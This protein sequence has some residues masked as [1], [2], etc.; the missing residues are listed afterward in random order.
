MAKQQNSVQHYLQIPIE[1]NDV[2]ASAKALRISLLK[3]Q[4]MAFDNIDADFLRKGD[5]KSLQTVTGLMIQ[6]QDIEENTPPK[7]ESPP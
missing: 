7:S 1:G 4:Q 2:A 6:L 5:L 3:L